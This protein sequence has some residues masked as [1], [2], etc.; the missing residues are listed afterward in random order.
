MG[1]LSQNN[2]PAPVLREFIVSCDVIYKYATRRQ[3][4][5]KI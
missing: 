1:E 3:L 2:D 5:T 4:L